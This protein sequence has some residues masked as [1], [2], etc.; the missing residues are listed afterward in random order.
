MRLF[1]DDLQTAQERTKEQSNERAVEQRNEQTSEQSNIPTDKQTSEQSNKPTNRP[2]AARTHPYRGNK[3][4]ERNK[5]QASARTSR[6]YPYISPRLLPAFAVPL[7]HLSTPLHGPCNGIIGTSISYGTLGGVTLS[8]SAPC[9]TREYSHLPVQVRE[10]RLLRVRPRD[11]TWHPSR[12]A[13]VRISFSRSP[14]LAM[15]VARST[16]HGRLELGSTRWGVR[17]TQA[18]H[19]SEH[20]I[21][22]APKGVRKEYSTG[23]HRAIGSRSAPQ[24]TAATAQP[25]APQF[26]PREGSGRVGK[27]P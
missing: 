9:S 14:T 24:T 17:G 4:N 2:T 16:L 21:V 27:F 3:T 26:P 18:W 25:A 11:A 8:T 20:S 6:G 22:L 7:D 19:S 23:T 15:V 1:D 10:L 13:D 5:R 12:G